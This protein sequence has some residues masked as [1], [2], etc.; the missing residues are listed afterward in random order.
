MDRLAG[1]EGC[2]GA[3]KKT[4]RFGDF[5]RLAAALQ[6]DHIPRALSV[7]VALRARFDFTDADGID[8]WLDQTERGCIAFDSPV[9]RCQTD[10][11]ELAPR[12]EETTREASEQTCA[13]F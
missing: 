8:L 10:L 7:G 9:G 13:R 1:N 6:R 12:I 11:E 2:G 5:F 4:D 3:G